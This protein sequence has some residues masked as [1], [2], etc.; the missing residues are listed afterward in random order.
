[1]YESSPGP[2]PLSSGRGCA[3][4]RLVDRERR[5][6]RVGGIEHGAEVELLDLADLPPP[7][8][9]ACRAAVEVGDRVAAEQRRRAR[10]PRQM[11]MGWLVLVTWWTGRVVGPAQ[12]V[13]VERRGAVG[14]RRPHRHVADVAV[15]DRDH[16]TGD[17]AAQH[18]SVPERVDDGRV[19]RAVVLVGLA[20]HVGA[21]GPVARSSAASVSAT[22][23]IRL[24]ET[25]CGAGALSPISGYSSARYSTPPPS[26]SSACP[27]RPSSITIGSPT[28][29]AP[30]ASTYQSMAS[31][32]SRDGEVRQRGG[33]GHGGLG[34][35]GGGVR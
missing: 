31:R 23:S 17:R 13:A 27:M 25:A 15:L 35:F 28:T 20:L 8:R 12:H 34:R 9:I 19:A 4:L 6:L 11:P 26:A 14:V 30:N 29:R 22:C 18:P 33:P 32:A 1:M 24:T 16:R 3:G 5:A 21:A 10:R 7:S 2:A